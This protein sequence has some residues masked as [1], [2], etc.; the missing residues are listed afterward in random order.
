MIAPIR[1]PC[2]FAAS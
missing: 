2:D 1:I